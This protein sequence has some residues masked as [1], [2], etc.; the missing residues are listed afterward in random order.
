MKKIVLLLISMTFTIY[1]SGQIGMGTTTPNYAAM[2][3][4]T[5]DTAGFLPPRMTHTQM[6]ALTSKAIAGLLVYNI[7]Y[8][9]YYFYNGIYRISLVKKKEQSVSE[10]VT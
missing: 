4:I 9:T 1:G 10:E 6:N 2:L 8:K 7:T 3:D 5:C